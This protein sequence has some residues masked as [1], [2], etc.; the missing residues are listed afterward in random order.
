MDDSAI[1]GDMDEY[2]H[3]Y[4]LPMHA[5]AVFEKATKLSVAMH[6]YDVRIW[7]MLPPTRSWH[8][9]TICRA[10]KQFDHAGC[11]A[12]DQQAVRDELTRRPNGF[13]KICHAG[14]VE[15]VACVNMLDPT[16]MT[17][18]PAMVLFAGQARPGDDLH[19]VSPLTA[20]NAIEQMNLK[21]A[22]SSRSSLPVVNAS[23]A[24]T[25]LELLCQLAARLEQW[26]GRMMGQ[27]VGQTLGPL[28]DALAGVKKHRLH[29]K[30]FTQASL[31]PDPTDRRRQIVLFIRQ[32]HVDPVTIDDLA[33]AMNLSPGRAAHVVRSLTGK[34]FG[35][36]LTEARVRTAASLLSHTN[37][38]VLD[39]ALRSGFGDISNFHRRFKASLDLSPLQYKKRVEVLTP[40]TISV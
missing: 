29:T 6:V 26:L 34:S 3:D 32:R 12:F 33:Q 14:L 15:W 13:V 19:E 4:D 2:G 40:L 10:A 35:Q 20:A 23:D 39:V 7:P 17:M 28:A 9:N 30:A 37:L 36:L 16:S 38:S 5:M 24:K 27:G 1:M 31:S 11:M 18:R 25:Q 22:R 21:D 8:D